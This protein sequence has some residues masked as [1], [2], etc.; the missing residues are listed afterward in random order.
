MANVVAIAKEQ[1]PA[2]DAEDELNSMISLKRSIDMTIQEMIEMNIDVEGILTES[3]EVNTGVQ[4]AAINYAKLKI[5]SQKAIQPMKAKMHS[6]SSSVESPIDYNKSALKSLPLASD[7]MK[8]NCQYFSFDQ[9]SQTSASHAATVASFVSDTV[10]MSGFYGSGK[11]S[12]E[13]SASAQSQVNSQH[14][15][16]S[17]AG[18]L[19]VTITAT[20]KNALVWAP[21]IMDVDKSVRCWNA[22][23]PDDMIDPTKPDDAAKILKKANTKD[24]KSFNILSG[25]TFGS[26]FVAMVHVLNTTSTSSS[27]SMVSVAASMQETFEVGSWFASASGGFGVSSTFSNSAKNL[28]SQNNVTSHASIITMGIIPSIKSNTLKTAVKGFSDFS[29]DKAMES[30]AK[31]QGATAGANKTVGS[32][33]KAAREGGQMISLQNSK[34]SSVLSGVSDLDEQANKIIDT[35][36]VMT[37]LDD[38]IDRC[39][40]GGDNLGVPINYYLKPITQSEIVEAYLNKYYP[41][42]FTHFGSPDDSAPAEKEG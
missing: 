41:N 36:S 18:T 10:K 13:A 5:S 35:N 21:Y 26:S 23:N 29:P 39:V 3:E 31:L 32:D 8:M 37:A 7:S 22:L 16:H 34:I 24:D 27:Q 1:Q 9:N 4:N 6:V 20:H 30:L 12:S 40:Q 19:V 11:E 2:D 17:V 28:L 25:V 38:Y 14:A 33:A 15:N 42:K